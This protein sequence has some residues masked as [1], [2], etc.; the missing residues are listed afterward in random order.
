MTTKI[1]ISKKLASFIKNAPYADQYNVVPRDTLTDVKGKGLMETFFLESSSS[2]DIFK[3]FE[4]ELAHVDSLVLN[5]VTNRNTRATR[6]CGDNVMINAVT[7]SNSISAGP[8]VRFGVFNM[9]ATGPVMTV[10]NSNDNSDAGKSV[11]CCGSQNGS[12]SSAGRLSSLTH[13]AFISGTSHS[14]NDGHRCDLDEIDVLRRRCKAFETK[15]RDANSAKSLNDQDR[16]TANFLMEENEARAV[17]LREKNILAAEKLRFK[18]ESRAKERADIILQNFNEMALMNP[19]EAERIKLK[20]DIEEM[21]IKRAQDDKAALLLAKNTKKA[22][23]LIARNSTLASI[24][25]QQQV[26]TAISL[27]I[28]QAVIAGRLKLADDE[29][30]AKPNSDPETENPDC[31]EAS[32]GCSKDSKN[33]KNNGGSGNTSMSSKKRERLAKFV[34]DS[35]TRKGNAAIT[36]M[37]KTIAQAQN[38]YDTLLQEEEME[39]QFVAEEAEKALDNENCSEGSSSE[40]ESRPSSGCTPMVC[41]RSSDSVSSDDTSNLSKSLTLLSSTGSSNQSSSKQQRTKDEIVAGILPYTF[42]DFMDRDFDVLCVSYSQPLAIT[43][44]IL[45]IIEGVTGDLSEI[46]VAQQ[47]WCKF[48]WKIGS[49]YNHCAYHNYHHAFTVVQFMAILLRSTGAMEKLKPKELFVALI[50]AAIHDVD[51]RGFNNTF[52]VNS[53]SQLAIKYDGKSPLEKHHLDVTFE[54]MRDPSSNPLAR[55]SADEQNEARKNIQRMV[56][57]TD[58]SVHNDLV[59]MLQEHSE[60]DEPFDFN[61]QEDKGLYLEAILHAADIS[62][63]VRPFKQSE[64][65]AA[66]LAVEFN[67]QAEKE[68]AMGLPVQAHMVQRKMADVCKGEIGFLTSVAKPYWK[69]LGRCFDQTLPEIEALDRNVQCWSNLSENLE[70]SSCT[71]ESIAARILRCTGNEPTEAVSAF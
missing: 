63:S 48:L 24:I 45:I 3:E 29:E 51:H 59:R 27:E 52:H 33:E 14:L 64:I 10:L 39:A 21:K 50:A 23:D 61:N 71:T 17:A 16:V 31:D 11:S 49:K 57:Q 12:I 40:C 26:E 70:K 65:L 5:S 54:I 47:A 18:I 6:N 2:R 25:S 43:R 7:S 46:N 41:D 22:N 30:L 55:W 66:R 56:L 42:A 8:I 62:N 28:D 32:S 67:T 20:A 68:H 19:S 37:V 1:H 53:K 35:E 15:Y 69:A 36:A 9:V 13:T 34:E 58:M 44:A 4:K 60:K 38:A